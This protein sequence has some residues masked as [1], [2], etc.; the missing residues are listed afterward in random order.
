MSL[1]ARSDSYPT[2]MSGI[3]VL[4]H[5]KLWKKDLEFCFLPTRYLYHF[6]GKKISVIKLSVSVFVQTTG[7][8]IFTVR[9]EPIRLPEIQYPV[10]LVFNIFHYSPPL[11]R[12]IVSRL[13][14]ET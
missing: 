2:F 6:E 8:R 7:Y 13:T 11:P 10:R 4:L 1:F 9:R 12:I 5:K 14:K 3:I